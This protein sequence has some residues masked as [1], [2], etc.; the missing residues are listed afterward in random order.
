MQRVNPQHIKRIP[1]TSLPL[2]PLD[3]LHGAQIMRRVDVADLP[4]RQPR[5]LPLQALRPL[6][7]REV[8]VQ[9][10]APG[11]VVADGFVVRALDAF[12]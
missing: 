1:A 10:R 8:A 11:V 4:L 5:H 9:G 7:Q 3:R 6:L 2:P 12:G